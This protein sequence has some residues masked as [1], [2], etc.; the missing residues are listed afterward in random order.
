MF[1]KTIG[2]SGLTSRFKGFCKSCY[3]RQY[4]QTPKRKAYV[5]SQAYRDSR[6]PYGKAR[7][8]TDAFKQSMKKYSKTDKFKKQQAKYRMSEKA[9]FSMGLRQAKKRNIN[10]E[11]TFEQFQILA[12]NLCHYCNGPL[13]VYGY[14]LDRKNNKQ[15]YT[16]ENTVSC[17]GDCNRTKGDRLTYEE[18]VA[19]SNLLKEMRHEKKSI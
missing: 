17:C 9:R 12:Q 5:K 16:I 15:S 19:I 4:E 2:C 13:S 8:Q 18:M 10:W 6:K 14:N 11:I 3:Y 7:A 1:C